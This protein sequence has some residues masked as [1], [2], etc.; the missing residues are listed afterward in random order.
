MYRALAK[1]HAYVEYLINMLAKHEAEQ[2]ESARDAELN[3]KKIIPGLSQSLSELIKKRAQIVDTEKK[4]QEGRVLF[5][6][7]M[8]FILVAMT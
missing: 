3:L 6:A 8:T 1:E 5:F 7:I 4:S 2:F